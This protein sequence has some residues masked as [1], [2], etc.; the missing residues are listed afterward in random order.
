MAAYN[1][2]HAELL[3]F[4]GADFDFGFCIRYNP[5]SRPLRKSALLGCSGALSRIRNDDWPS[6]E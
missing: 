2:H 4:R 3:Q 1:S 5:V 6:Y